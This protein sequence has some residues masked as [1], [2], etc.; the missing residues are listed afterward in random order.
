MGWP[1]NYE[2]ASLCP[3]VLLFRFRVYPRLAATVTNNH[4]CRVA[5]GLQI[6]RYSSLLDESRDLIPYR[7]QAGWF[8]FGG[9]FQKN[10][11]PAESGSNRFR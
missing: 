10:H 9:F 11:V 2:P 5:Q 6:F 4:L 7:V 1:V 3:G 8:L